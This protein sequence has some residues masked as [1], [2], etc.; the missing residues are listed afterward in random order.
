MRANLLLSLAVV[1]A[2]P[3]T[4]QTVP[5]YFL[6]ADE[7]IATTSQLVAAEDQAKWFG[8]P[9][10]TWFGIG[11][12]TVTFDLGR[13]RVTNGTGVDLVVYEADRDAVEFSSFTLWLSA[14]GSNFHN[15][16]SSISTSPPRITGDSAHSNVNF[17]RGYDAG[18]AVTALGASE[19]RFIRLIGSATGS[20]LNFG[21]SR[22]F[23]LDAIGLINFNELPPDVVAAVP[24]PNSWAMLIAGFGLV[25]AMARRRRALPA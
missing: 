11:G 19:F 17:R 12:Q 24:E 4:A 25:G 20:N 9:D 18:G 10:D 15:I 13:F 6:D 21:P 5:G 23:D 16:S 22:G 2:V 3:A 8:A 7:T 14:D 1:L